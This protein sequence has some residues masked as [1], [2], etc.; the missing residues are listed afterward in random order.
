MYRKVKDFIQDWQRSSDGT[1]AVFQ[2]VTEEKKGFSIIEGH[3]SL[4]WISWHLKNSPSFFMRQIGLS[5][6]VEL[7]PSM[8]LLQ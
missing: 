2:A 1:I 4:E 7:N 8:Y 6:E 5:L 3:N